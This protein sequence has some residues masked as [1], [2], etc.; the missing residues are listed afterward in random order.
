M[1]AKTRQSTVLGVALASMTVLAVPLPVM[2]RAF[3]ILGRVLASVIVP[4]TEKVIV[5]GAP[6]AQP[7]YYR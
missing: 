2:V 3:V 5:F 1:K 7:Y 4:L 6:V